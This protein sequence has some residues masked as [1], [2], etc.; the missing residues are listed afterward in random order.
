MAVAITRAMAEQ[1]GAAA[2]ISQAAD[3]MRQQSEQ[4][5]KALREQARAIKDMTTA[6]ASTAKQIKTI[7]A[8][9]QEH[10][11]AAAG[12][13]DDVSMLREAVERTVEGFRQTQTSTEDLLRRAEA[14]ASIAAGA[15]GSNGHRARANGR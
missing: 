6:A 9:N 4:S 15:N 10:S 14:L 8:A 12:I 1:S 3:S 5:A 11:R 7:T 13:I 2:E